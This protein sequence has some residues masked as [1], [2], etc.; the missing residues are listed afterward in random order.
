MGSGAAAPTGHSLYK[1]H[2]SFF[3]HLAEAGESSQQP[4]PPPPESVQLAQMSF[5]A[6][7]TQVYTGM[8]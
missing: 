2:L 3:L 5:V 4:L 7:V 1:D 8:P 6:L